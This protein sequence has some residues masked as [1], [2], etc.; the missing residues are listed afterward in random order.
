LKNAQSKQLRE[1]LEA[2]GLA[3]ECRVG[4]TYLRPGQRVGAVLDVLQGLFVD[5]RL[6]EFVVSYRSLILIVKADTQR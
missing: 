3:V 6:M 5:R 1:N 2:I 4:T